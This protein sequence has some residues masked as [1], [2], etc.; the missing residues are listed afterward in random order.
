M[1]LVSTPLNIQPNLSRIIPSIMQPMIGEICRQVSFSYGDELVL[2]FGELTP[3]THPQLADLSKG[4]WQL[5]TQATPWRVKQDDQ[6]LVATATSDT[7]EEI[8]QAKILVKQL[9]NKKLLSLFVEKNTIHLILN[10]EDEYQLIIEPDLTNDSGLAYWELLMPTE[11][12]LS[13]GPG[14]FWSCKSVYDRS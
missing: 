9:E 11:Q 13:I 6:V 12:I 8:T 10:F 14:Y 4:S 7:E 3:Y 1:A 5:T 2:D